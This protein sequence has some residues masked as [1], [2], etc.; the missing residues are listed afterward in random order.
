[1]AKRKEYKGS[2]GGDP[3]QNKQEQ[4]P[5]IGRPAFQFLEYKASQKLK[6]YAEGS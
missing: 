3:V 1:V 2:A 6:K 5:A 4:I